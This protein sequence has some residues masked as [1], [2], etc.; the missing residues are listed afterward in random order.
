MIDSIEEIIARAIRGENGECVVTLPREFQGLPD[1]AH[2]GSVLG[3]FDALA[4]VRGAR[5]VSGIYR[6]RVPLGVPLSLSI[7]RRPSAVALALGD[8]RGVLVDGAIAAARDDGA[9]QPHTAPSPADRRTL[10]VARSCLAC[11]LD[12]PIGLQVALGFDADRVGAQIV[13]AERFARV[14]GTLATLALTTLLD[15]VAFWLGALH[16]GESGMTTDLAVT[17]HRPVAAG[18]P[19]VVAGARADTAPL[20]TDPRYSQTSA[21]VGDD[22]GRLVASARITFVAVR[23]TA[24]RLAQ[25]MLE[26]N[27]REVV[28]EVFPAYV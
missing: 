25:A 10:P 8:A 7:D 26:V 22:A 20:P 21:T 11:G 15:E 28:R 6:R 14:D 2:G 19:L 3:V 12:N 27:A 4:G 18:T 13:P 9:G 5:S 17:L 1:T 24:K 16:T 23:G